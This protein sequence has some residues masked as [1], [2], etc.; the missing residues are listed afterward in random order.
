ME[1]ALEKPRGEEARTRPKPSTKA[2]TG[3]PKAEKKHAIADEKSEESSDPD[4]T[5]TPVV[6]GTNV[7]VVP[8]DVAAPQKPN[9]LGIEL[10]GEGADSL[11]VPAETP[12]AGPLSENNPASAKKMGDPAAR[13]CELSPS[14]VP[15]EKR[16]V[17]APKEST[18]HP[19]ILDRLRPVRLEGESPPEPV[20]PQGQNQPIPGS[21]EATNIPLQSP[22]GIAV[23]KNNEQMKKTA[24][25]SSLS[26]TGDQ[27]LPSAATPSLEKAFSAV[28][29][30]A[31]KVESETHAVNPSQLL[32]A[33]SQI[34]VESAQPSTAETAPDAQAVSKSPLKQQILHGVLEMKLLGSDS[35]S[36]IVRP[37][38]QTELHLL[39][40]MT[41]GEVSVQAKLSNGDLQSLGTEWNTLQQ[42][43]AQQG[44]RLEPLEHT[45]A[46]ANS[47]QGGAS[48]NSSSQFSRQ[49]SD[50]SDRRKPAFVDEFA[51]PQFQFF[52][53]PAGTRR[54][55]E[56]WA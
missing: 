42:S 56:S 47:G 12:T 11:V 22:D 27:K 31:L 14:E 33:Y 7:Q 16:T 38:G 52:P 23:A 10:S 34:S 15:A 6:S 50:E 24:E 45:P 51:A 49:D 53:K 48:A 18:E 3:K 19:E 1:R 17:I 25:T 46:A 30:S 4:E 13:I 28:S 20:A 41:N 43:L 40:A 21:K 8:L 29:S 44:I 2:N 32:S 26:P 36:V 39:L 5:K 55:W 54:F 35:M 9:Q 37:D